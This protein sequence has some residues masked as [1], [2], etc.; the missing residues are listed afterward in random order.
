MRIISFD[1]GIKNF[2]YVIIDVNKDEK[3]HIIEDWGILELCPKEKNASK[4][5][6]IEIGKNMIIKLD[7][8]LQEREKL[9]LILI[10]NQ[11]GQNAIRMKSVQGMV[12]MYF[13][14]RE[15]DIEDIVNYNAIHKLKNFKH[16]FE[17]KPKTTYAER[18]KMS[19]NVCLELVKNTYTDY[20]TFYSKN[21]KKDDLADCLL[22]CLDYL[23]K[24]KMLEKE[25]FELIQI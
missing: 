6:V 20:D 22:Q 9:D 7:E 25:F 12:S 3:T 18:K 10:E 17:G 11:I 16:L 24:N 21:K 4:V 5:D 13:L 14:M 2:A 19:K 15:Y 1:I 8:L 23:Y